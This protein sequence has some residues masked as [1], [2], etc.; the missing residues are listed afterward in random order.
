MRELFRELALTDRVQGPPT[1]L[2]RDEAVR[3]GREYVTVF[4][5]LLREIEHRM[6]F[7]E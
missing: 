2:T 7:K 3:V 1:I 5:R 4:R 6:N